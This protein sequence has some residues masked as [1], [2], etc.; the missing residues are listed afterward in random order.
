MK[1]HINIRFIAA[2]VLCILIT[3]PI[4]S[5]TRISSPYSR[6]GIGDLH[7]YNNTAVLAM[8]GT[9]LGL[10]DPLRINFSN[11][12]S[13]AALEPNSFIFEAGVFSKSVRLKTETV[14]QT[15]N[16][17]SLG[18]LLMGFPVTKSWKTSM[19]L[20]PYSDVGYKVVDIQSDTTL[21]RIRRSYEGSGG[22]HQVYFGNALALGKRFSL[23]LNLTYLFGTLEKSRS[24]SFPDSMN[25]LNTRVLN[26]TDVGDFKVSAGL[27][28]IQPLGKE[29]NLKAGITYSPEV[30][31][32]IKDKI[33]AYTYIVSLTGNDIPRDTIVSTPDQQGTM[34]LPADIGFGIMLHKN[35]RW[36]IGA[37]YRW[38]NWENFTFFDRSD[39]LN[40]SMSISLGGQYNP[41][42]TVL[43]G[44]LKKIQYR[45]GARYSQTYLEL[46]DN[47][48]KEF[49]IS[50]GL[51]LPLTRTKSTINVGIEAGARGTTENNLIKE[52]FFKFSLGFSIYER[53]FEKRK[54][55]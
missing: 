36:M 12:A 7:L 4:V 51:G 34:R 46:R 35:N 20:L 21:G 10:S 8:G 9:S 26:T 6:F 29:F 41:A 11:P 19:G 45:F 39:S 28:Y 13:Y 50:F 27:Q 30:T 15:G 23:G 25:L 33:L 2:L 42:S 32:S 1:T 14:S 18:H 44:Y 3:E 55:Y 54:Y 49:G 40:N 52:S 24:L 17:T 37:D 31:I 38:Q 43:S 47:R 22:V 48:I 53:W 16:Y 5:Q